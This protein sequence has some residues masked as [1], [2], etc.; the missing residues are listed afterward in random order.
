MK[1]KLIKEMRNRYSDVFTFTY[2]P[3]IDKNLVLWEG[4]FEWCRW[5]WEN[6]VD[7]SD[8]VLSMVDPSGGPYISSGMEAKFVMMPELKDMYVDYMSANKDDQGKISS[9]NIHLK[10]IKQ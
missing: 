6:D 5:G 7:P 3:A 8:N 2:D 4:N 1:K 9:F 10:K